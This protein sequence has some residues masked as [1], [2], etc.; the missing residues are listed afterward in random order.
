MDADQHVTLFE[1]LVGEVLMASL[2]PN[3]RR[4][5]PR[6]LRLSMVRTE[7]ELLLSLLAQ[8][9]AATHDDAETSFGHAA[10]RLP[11]LRM[12][13]LPPADGQLKGLSHCLSALR[14]LAPSAA[15]QV[16]DAMSHCALADHKVTDDESTL[17]AATC[18]ALEIPMPN[19]A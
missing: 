7:L 6:R 12:R 2:T 15:A 1:H 10:A 11:E 17:V 8:A 4:A 9:G 16:I 3:P 14:A 13:L 18:L 19:W 5:Q